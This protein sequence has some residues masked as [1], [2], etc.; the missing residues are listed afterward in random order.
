MK[1]KKKSITPLV[2]STKLEAD[3]V[4]VYGSANGWLKFIDN[5]KEETVFYPNGHTI[6]DVPEAWYL[7]GKYKEDTV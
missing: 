4:L 2:E 6:E 1:K 5:Q 3:E 7:I